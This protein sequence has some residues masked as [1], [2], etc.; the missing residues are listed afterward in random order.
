MLYRIVLYCI[1]EYHIVP[2]CTV[3]YCI[4]NT[5]LYVLYHTALCCTVMFPLC[6]C[7]L[8][9][10]V[11]LYIIHDLTYIRLSTNYCIM[12]DAHNCQNLKDS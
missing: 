6:K 8:Y 10:N 12:C 2:Y 3:R 7:L 5:L 9:R 1:G 4:F 11:F